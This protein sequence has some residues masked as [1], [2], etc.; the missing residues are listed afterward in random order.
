MGRTQKLAAIIKEGVR[1]PQKIKKGL[2]VLKNQGPEIFKQRLSASVNYEP[3]YGRVKKEKLKNYSGEILFSIVMPVY[4]VEIKWL[5][6]AIESIEKQNYKNWEICIA[7]DCSTKQEVREHLSAMKNSRI[8][9]KL[10]EKNQGISGQPMRQQR[11]HPESIS[12]LWIMMMS[13]HRLH[14]MNFIRR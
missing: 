4:N 1:N 13:L 12:F 14:Y 9:I 8:K 3:G 10:L 6:K 2:K 5:D 7:D 11:L